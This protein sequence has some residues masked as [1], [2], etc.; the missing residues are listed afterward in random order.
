MMQ[1]V[2]IIVCVIIKVLSVITYWLDD[3]QNK[4]RKR[5]RAHERRIDG[6]YSSNYPALNI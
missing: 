3:K 2:T 5:N 6:E 1:L 4:R